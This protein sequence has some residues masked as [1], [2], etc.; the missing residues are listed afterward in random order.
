MT[1]NKLPSVDEKVL[2]SERG[3]DLIIQQGEIFDHEDVNSAKGI[4]GRLLYYEEW[5]DRKL[6]VEPHGA[7]RVTPDKKKP[8]KTWM[9]F[10]MWSSSGAFALSSITTGMLPWEYGLSLTQAI[11]IVIFGTFLGCAVA[12]GLLLREI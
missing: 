11:L 7:R 10:F 1:T 8:P 2:A 3:L 9:M 12:V 6:G 4:L 5:L